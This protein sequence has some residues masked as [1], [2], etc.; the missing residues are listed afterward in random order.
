M[1]LSGCRPSRRTGRRIASA[2]V[3]L[4]L[5]AA[6]GMPRGAHADESDEGTRYNGGFLAVGLL[7]G[8]HFPDAGRSTDVGWLT[9]AYA[10][11]STV[12]QIIDVQGEYHAAGG[13]LESSHGPVD[14][15][16]HSLSTSVNLH[17]FFLQMLNN[18]WLWFALTSF[19]LQAGGS[20][21][22]AD[23]AN[24]REDPDAAFSMHVGLG[25][26]VPLSQPESSGA[27]WLG[28]NWRWKTVFSEWQVGGGE[29]DPDAHLLA[30]VLSY[31]YHNLSFMRL[32]RPGDLKYR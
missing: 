30:I 32:E 31:R 25:F 17:P 10:R 8:A 2:A 9:G 20:V 14:Y 23:L 28:V 4:V 7:G 3:Y 21:E 27:F 11:F 5:A 13:S 26:D 19:Y 6:M 18:N 22:F 15:I 24:V 29:L 16:R 12:L 1:F